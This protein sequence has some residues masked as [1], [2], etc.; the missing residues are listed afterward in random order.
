MRAMED[1]SFDNEMA[2]KRLRLEM[3]RLEDAAGGSLDEIKQKMAALRGE[4]EMLFGEREDLRLAGAGSE[5]LGTYDDQIKALQDQESAAQDILKPI[6]ECRRRW[7][8]S[9]VKPS[10]WTLRSP[11]PSTRSCA[12]STRWST[13]SMSCLR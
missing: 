1:A 7:I 10:A 3:M 5:I 11:S 9:S 8:G 12:R 2:Q 13:A 4:Q 6:K